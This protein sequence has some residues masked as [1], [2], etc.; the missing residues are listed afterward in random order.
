MPSADVMIL[1]DTP[2]EQALRVMFSEWDK[3]NYF[4]GRQREKL[5]RHF[6]MLLPTRLDEPFI[7]E[8]TIPK[9]NNTYTIISRYI[10]GKIV[11]WPYIKVDGEK[12]RR[13]I[14]ILTKKDQTKKYMPNDPVWTLDIYTGHFLSRYRE[15]INSNMCSNE[16][17][18]RYLQTNAIKS[19]PVPARLLNPAC[20]EDN[21][22]AYI[23][24]EGLAFAEK[25]ECTINGIP[26]LINENK[27][28]VSSKDMHYQQAVVS[29]ETSKKMKNTQI[30]KAIDGGAPPE[31]VF[32]TII[33]RL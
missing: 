13:K 22:C 9:S 12:C 17:F 24:Y 8:Y 32:K 1:Y 14:L 16:L 28:F 11:S 20:R 33:S 4:I 2:N 7:Q 31:E 26:A 10:G 19:T 15:R 5:N 30:K 29:L 6:M 18:A 27:T 25:K 21:Q 3:V 23:V